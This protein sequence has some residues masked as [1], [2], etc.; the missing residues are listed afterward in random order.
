MSKIEKRVVIDESTERVFDYLPDPVRSAEVWPGLIE[1]R[2][3][4]RLIGD[5]FYT[6]WLYKMSGAMF[7][8]SNFAF[9]YESDQHA[10]TRQLRAYDLAM[11]LRFQPDRVTGP[12]LAVDGDHT[13]WSQC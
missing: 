6:S 4:H 2:E 9:E 5:V 11:T 10:F 1:A 3:V 8:N 7:E 12:C 13:C